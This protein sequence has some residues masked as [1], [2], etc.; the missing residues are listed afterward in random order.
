[1]KANSKTVFNYVKEH[2]SEN[3]TAPDIAEATGLGIKSV[4]GIVTSA[5]CRKGKDYMVR[6]PGEIE[7]EDAEGN[8][9]HKP[10]NFIKLTEKGKESTVESIEAE[11]LAIAQAKLKAK[12][13]E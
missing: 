8:V 13:A 10:V 1:M 2:E 3:L 5:F 12:L 6:V 9:T 11:E 4:N 7:I